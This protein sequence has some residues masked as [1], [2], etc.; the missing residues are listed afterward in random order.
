MIAARLKHAG[1]SEQD[2]FASGAV[3][4]K[5]IELTGVQ[6]SQLMLFVQ[7]AVVADGIPIREEAIDRLGRERRRDYRWLL[8]EDWPI[9]EAIRQNG[10][11]VPDEKTEPIFKRLLDS[12]AALHYVNSDEWYDLN[13]LVAQITPPTESVAP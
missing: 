12:R 5:L 9:L 11:F 6:P 13:P 4:D 10:A 7:S 3:R 1:F 2:L 8:R